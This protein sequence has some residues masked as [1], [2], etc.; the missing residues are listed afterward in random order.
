MWGWPQARAITPSAKFVT[1]SHDIVWGTVT[2]LPL[3]RCMEDS[4]PLANSNSKSDRIGGQCLPCP[5]LYN[6]TLHGLTSPSDTHTIHFQ[7]HVC[8]RIHCKC[9]HS[10]QAGARDTS[11]CRLKRWRD[12][13]ACY[14]RVCLLLSSRCGD[15]MRNRMT[16]RRYTDG[17]ITDISLPFLG[18]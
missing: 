3:T 8:L 4:L 15:C 1:L 9:L 14:C 17:T 10:S 11:E 6:T 16:L 13:K 12:L 7:I 5:P 18:R 2:N